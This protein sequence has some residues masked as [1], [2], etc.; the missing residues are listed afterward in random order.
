MHLRSDI[1]Q[2]LLCNGEFIKARAELLGRGYTRSRSIVDVSSS[3][4]DLQLLDYIS[5]TRDNDWNL[6]IPTIVHMKD[7]EWCTSF[8]HLVHMGDCHNEEYESDVSNHDNNKRVSI[9][10]RDC[11]DALYIWRK[12]CITLFCSLYDSG[13]LATYDCD[14]INSVAVPEPGDKRA[15]LKPPAKLCLSYNGSDPNKLFGTDDNCIEVAKSLL[16][17]EDAWTM[18]DNSD[19][20]FHYDSSFR[21]DPSFKISKRKGRRKRR[22]HKMK[23]T[24][25][26]RILSIDISHLRS[27]VSIG[28]SLLSLAEFSQNI[29]CEAFFHKKLHHLGSEVS[30]LHHEQSCCLNDAI[31]VLSFTATTLLYILSN[32][33][34]NLDEDDLDE[35]VTTSFGPLFC[36]QKFALVREACK[37]LLVVTGILAA[38]AWYSLGRMVNESYSLHLKR[39]KSDAV[40]QVMLSSFERAL[41]VL[42]STKWTSLKR[43]PMEL[44]SLQKPLS[45]YKCLL[46]SSINHSMGVNLYELGVFKKA[47]GY[48]DEA[49]RF[50]RQLLEHLRGQAGQNVDQNTVFATLFNNVV[51]ALKNSVFFPSPSSLTED[52]FLNVLKYSI[53]HSCVLLPKKRIETS[54]AENIELSLSLTLEYAALTHHAVQSYQTALS[55]FQEAL[56]LRTI[57]V[58]KSSLDVAS[59]H[60]NMGVVH[61]DL[62]QYEA[63]ISRYYESL[64][65]RLDQLDNASTNHD[66]EEIQNSILLTLKC[67]GHVYKVIHDIDNSV[68]CYV[69]ASE[70]LTKKYLSHREF[71][72]EWSKMGL[73]LDLAV[74]V[75]T[76]FFTEMKKSGVDDIAK[77][78]FQAINK[79]ALWYV[80]AA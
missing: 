4:V 19:Q 61:D 68:C 58:G 33:L 45:Q 78:H 9:S 64:R 20:I 36:L 7:I 50:R 6:L 31:E 56:I 66:T 57:H 38:D 72:D 12:E 67:M 59:L 69:K 30:H 54:E 42:S 73:R 10:L 52:M 47:M 44:E 29:S 43:L 8:C 75:P 48:L 60:F 11:L 80:L 22:D 79:K 15:P 35:T 28:R 27:A 62:E 5:Q 41:L 76:I 16:A 65:I 46:Q 63:A 34:D 17:R 23:S 39:S 55:L 40:Q 51:G 71:A 49:T 32:S 18:K 37:P 3:N 1:F 25:L 26:A 2:N 70:M 21:D 13:K 77:L 24:S 53:Y 74:P 14:S